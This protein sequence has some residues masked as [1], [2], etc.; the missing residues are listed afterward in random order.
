MYYDQFIPN[1]KTILIGSALWTMGHNRSAVVIICENIIET[2]EHI[3]LIH[4]Q[5]MQC[6][7]PF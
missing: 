5:L 4:G 3:E 2:V 6:K 7:M 1:F